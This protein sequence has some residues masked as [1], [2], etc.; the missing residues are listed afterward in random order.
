MRSKAIELCWVQEE[1]TLWFGWSMQ[2]AQDKQTSR[3]VE[4]L[5]ET[6]GGGGG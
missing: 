3:L 5:S 4:C 2:E 6:E 1:V